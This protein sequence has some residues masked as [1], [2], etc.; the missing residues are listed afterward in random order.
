MKKILILGTL[1]YAGLGLAHTCHISLYDPA[2]RPYLNFYSSNDKDCKA[3][4]QRCYTAISQYR[5]NPYQY[6]CYTI[7]MTEDRPQTPTRPDTNTTNPNPNT[8]TNTST[9]TN[10]NTSSIPKPSGEARRDVE[11]GE[12]VLHKGSRWIVTDRMD[13]NL[14]LKP[15][16]G[17]DKDIISNIPRRE[18]AITRGCQKEICTKS[19]VIELASKS[20]LSVEGIDM[21]GR[22][23]TQAIGSDKLNAPLDYRALAR[24]SGCVTSTNVGVCAGNTV[25]ARNNIY[26]KV[27]GIQPDDRVVLESEDND[28]KLYFDVDPRSLTVTR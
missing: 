16:G 1:L 10:T 6:K 9:N 4:A 28:R 23:I 14:S 25:I 27:A 20:Y 13:Q 7:S 3:A 17:K 11:T 12:T 8:N 2:D 15:V 21:D 5:L 19:S 22:Y 26:Y 18:V 24:T